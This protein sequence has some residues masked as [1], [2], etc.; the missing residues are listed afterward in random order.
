MRIFTLFAH[1]ASVCVL[2]FSATLPN[3]LADISLRPD[4]LWF[5]ES[6]YGISTNYSLGPA[7]D[8]AT[9]YS[10]GSKPATINDLADG[11]N[12]VQ[13]ARDLHGFHAD[14]VV[15]S[16][17]PAPGASFYPSD[18]LSPYAGAKST[19]RDLLADLITALKPFDIKLIVTIPIANGDEMSTTEQNSTGWKDAS[20][21]YAVWN[22]Y[23][24]A[25][26]TEMGIRYGAG[27]AGYWIE[28]PD[29]TA[30]FS[31]IDLPR[32][33][34]SLL[35]GD[36]DRIFIASTG[37]HLPATLVD[38]TVDAPQTTDDLGQ[39]Q[40]YPNGVQVP[41][42]A[43]LSP[44]KLARFIAFEASGNRNGVGT[45]VTAQPYA[46]AEGGWENGVAE[47]LKSVGKLIRPLDESLEGTFPSAAY[48]TPAGA[49]LSVLP[50]GIAATQSVDGKYQYLHVFNPPTGGMLMLPPP[51]DGEQFATAILLKNRH[52]LVLQQSQAGLTITLPSSDSWDTVDT[53]IKLIRQTP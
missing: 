30:V 32:L 38:A 46:G 40:G 37:S 31:N 29:S 8:V 49:T 12:E 28:N 24:N 35:A 47:P 33:K 52:K 4:K 51:V 22:T 26:I 45:L 2:L 34:E 3:A 14:Y 27:I 18:A 16:G 42:A 43:D 39:L 11:F 19:K 25:S 10:D 17:A 7:S 53:V 36:P 41:S 44:D 5:T 6:H 23:L 50:N 48:P 20:N 9:L 21:G 13:F 15:F 1:C